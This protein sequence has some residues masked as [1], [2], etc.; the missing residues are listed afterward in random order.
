MKVR[1]GK[2]LCVGLICLDVV[3]TCKE[4]PVEDTLQRT[5]SVSWQKGGNAANT[6]AVLGIL[7][8]E[9]DF[10]GSLPQSASDFSSKLMTS[11]VKAEM[12]DCGVGMQNVV[13]FTDKSLP[14]SCVILNKTKGSRTILHNNEGVTEPTFEDICR[15]NLDEYS[16][17]HFEGRNIPEVLKMLDHVTAYNQKHPD[18]QIIL[19]VDLERPNRKNIEQLIPYVDV[20]LVGRDFALG[21]GIQSAMEAVEHYRTVAKKRA[22]VV[23]PWGDT[24][25]AS[26]VAGA[27]DDV[28]LTPAVPPDHVIDTLGAGDTFLGALI[29]SLR[30]ERPLDDAVGYACA[31]AGFKCG[32]QGYKCLQAFTEKS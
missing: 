1:K 17:I 32:H 2:L 18:E 23:C 9:V 5:E 30:L 19:S 26:G 22:Y 24:G 4:F 6:S 12:E 21:K 15:L 16:W 20:L 28:I 7:G 31:V 27:V 10:M 11:F 8:D 3:T 13:N 25:A 29:H 14:F